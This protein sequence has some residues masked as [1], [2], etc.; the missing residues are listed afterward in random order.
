MLLTLLPSFK[1][2][3]HISEVLYHWRISENSTA[4]NPDSKPYSKRS[5]RLAIERYLKRIHTNA[6]IYSSGIDNLHNLWFIDD[7]SY[8]VT[9]LVDMT[10]AR[11]SAELFLESF[12]Q[13]NSCQNSEVLFIYSQ[14]ILNSKLETIATFDTPTTSPEIF[15]RG[16]K[17]AKGSHLL[18]LNGCDIFITPE[19]LEQLLGLFK[20]NGVGLVA[21]KSLYSDGNTKSFGVA[22]INQTVIPIGRGYEDAFPGYLCFMRD[23][24]NFSAVGSEGIVVSRDVFNKVGGFDKSF[25]LA[26]STIDLCIKIRQLGLRVVQSPCVKIQVIQK[27]PTKRYTYDCVFGDYP[28][29]QIM[30]L[31]NKWGV[32]VLEKDSYYNKNLMQSNGY[33][34]LSNF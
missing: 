21:P 10:D 28:Q 4:T 16:A 11:C 13:I 20:I 29:N 31:K 32:N 5:S 7:A 19:P 25:D 24:Q 22:L 1:N 33:F 17:F 9:V 34:Q 14:K 26:V 3:I 8:F 30:Q 15:N 18:F 2:A 12:Y 23:Y 6:K 27:T